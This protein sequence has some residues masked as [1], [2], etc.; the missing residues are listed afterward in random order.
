MRRNQWSATFFALLLFGSG[1]FSGALL[2]R[3]YSGTVVSAKTSETF[4]ERYLGEMKSKVHLSNQQM[5]QLEAILDETKAKYKAVREQ[6]RPAM[7]QI[8]QDQISRVETI[9]T[10][11]Q[12]PLY[13]RLVAEREQRSK[14]DDARERREESERAARRRAQYSQQ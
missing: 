14:E 4:R 6:S 10:P 9:L 7:M 1:V 12:V 2:Q 13:Q 11:E 5:Q 3:Y 8:K